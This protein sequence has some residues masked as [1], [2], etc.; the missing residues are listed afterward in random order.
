MIFAPFLPKISCL[1]VTA[2]GRFD[3]FQKSV[4]CYF[5][6]TY[7][8]K[9][10]IVVN[11]GPKEYQE[12]IA[13][14]L[15]D[16]EDVKLIFLNDWYSLGALRNISVAF[17]SGD[18]FVQWDDDDFNLPE[19]LVAQYNHLVRHRRSNICYLSDQLHYYQ[20]TNQLFWENWAEFCSG[21]WK[22][23]SL[24]PGTL[25]AWKNAFNHRYPSGGP[26]CSAGEDSVLSDEL[27][28]DEDRVTLLSGIGYL[29][30]YSY[31]G[32][33][34]WNIHHHSDISDH[35]SVPISQ[36]LS[37][38]DQICRAIDYLKFPGEVKVMGRNGLAFKHEANLD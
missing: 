22:K 9:E 7:T 32:L 4:R 8:N 24:I 31:H 28:E 16:R 18:I 34:V 20:T 33:N 3:L 36:M 10:L 37:Y 14:F 12:Q 2:A 11:E 19:R 6:Q 26:K 25:M 38:R 21:G 35:R 27:C 15:K 1:S 30:V 23:H 29:Q 17:A 13:D 5:D